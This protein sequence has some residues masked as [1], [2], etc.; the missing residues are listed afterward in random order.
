MP[1]KHTTSSHVYNI[2]VPDLFQLNNLYN[3]NGLYK[4]IVTHAALLYSMK[5]NFIIVNILIVVFPYRMIMFTEHFLTVQNDATYATLHNTRKKDE[6][7][8][9]PL[10]RKLKNIQLDEGSKKNY[11]IVRKNRL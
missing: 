6:A 2:Y 1:I 7:L 3:V 9:K 4:K 5:V 8:Y 10:Y 11:L